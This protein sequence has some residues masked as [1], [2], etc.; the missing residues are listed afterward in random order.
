M[1]Y[2]KSSNRSPWHLLVQLENADLYAEISQ[3]FHPTIPP[4][5]TEVKFMSVHHGCRTLLVITGKLAHVILLSASGLYFG[6]RRKLEARLALEDFT[7]HYRW[8]IT[9]VSC[10]PC[11]ALTGYRIS[12]KQYRSDQSSVEQEENTRA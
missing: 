5:S 1:W 11:V 9:M 7:V 10:V 2:R 6:T 4:K 3:R 8:F 12:N